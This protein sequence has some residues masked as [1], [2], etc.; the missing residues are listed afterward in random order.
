MKQTHKLKALGDV[1][2]VLATA[3][4]LT[5]AARSLGVNRSSL[6]RWITAGKV[7][8]PGGVR[9][10]SAEVTAN[11]APGD[12]PVAITMPLEVL[13]HGPRPGKDDPEKDRQ[14]LT[15]RTFLHRIADVER[16]FDPRV[17]LDMSGEQYA[18]WKRRRLAWLA[19]LLSQEQQ[20]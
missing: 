16:E 4:S 7:R 6:H 3:P 10:Q 17:V 20:D 18:D 12:S 14:W 19:A 13:L 2:A 9:T 8:Q 1:S 5:A 11:G 15:Q